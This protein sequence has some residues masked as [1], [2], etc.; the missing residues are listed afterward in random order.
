MSNVLDYLGNDA[1]D[2]LE[3]K[4]Q[5]VPKEELTLPGGDFVERVF[6]QSDRSKKVQDNLKRLY[7]HGRLGGSGYLSILLACQMPA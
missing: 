7:K 1:K 6:S 2:L 3:H 4:C 5:T